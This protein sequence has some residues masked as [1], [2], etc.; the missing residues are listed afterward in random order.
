VLSGISVDGIN[1]QYLVPI[2]RNFP[3]DYQRILDW[4]PLL[5]MELYRLEKF[6][7]IKL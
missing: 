5:D 4:F 3:R 2:K 1:A 7:G 6:G